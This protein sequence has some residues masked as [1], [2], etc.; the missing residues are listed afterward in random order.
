MAKT[1]R[2]RPEINE[3][4][5]VTLAF[6]TRRLDVRGDSKMPKPVNNQLQ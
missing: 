4:D 5:F 6:Y 3:T 2:S 1:S